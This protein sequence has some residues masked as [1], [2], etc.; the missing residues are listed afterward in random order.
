MRRALF[1][2]LLLAGVVESGTVPAAAHSCAQPA[3]I[4]VGQPAT[5]NVSV[6]AEAAPVVAVT[7]TIPEGF[8]A[9]AVAPPTGWRELPRQ[10]ADIIL[11]GGPI[12]R[13]GCTTFAVTGQAGKPATLA[14]VI[15]TRT[16]DGTVERFDRTEPGSARPAQ[17]VFA[18]TDQATATTA[19]GAGPTAL[20]PATAFAEDA[21]GEAAG[22]DRD[23]GGSGGTAA[24][25]FG[26]AA[27]VAG[28]ATVL[29]RRRGARPRPR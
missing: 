2:L 20:P 25:V 1:A 24:L 10:G 15:T 5:V 9:T 8:V 7:I 23:G 28:A 6:G 22:D 18:G 13:F 12:A 21:T 27:V 4:P 14:F 19:T 26:A 3:V 16:A 29:F 17:V 11:E